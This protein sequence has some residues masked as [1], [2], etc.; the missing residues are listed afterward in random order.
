VGP[1]VRARLTKNPL[2][3]SALDAD[4]P[5]SEATVTFEFPSDQPAT[6]DLTLYGL[7]SRHLRDDRRDLV[8]EIGK[9]RAASEHLRAPLPS[10]GVADLDALFD[11]VGRVT[12]QIWVPRYSVHQS[13]LISSLA[14][15]LAREHE[16]LLHLE[17]VG[18][19]DLDGVSAFP[20]W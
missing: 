9:R 6:L 14:D 15:W 7:S 10:A 12:W 17:G 8:A 4:E 18:F 11:L 20:I 2:D 19:V 16:I 5:L 3:D 1:G 13:A